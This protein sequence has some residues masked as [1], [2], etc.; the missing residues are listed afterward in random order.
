MTK[1][2]WTKSKRN[3][4][5]GAGTALGMIFLAAAGSAENG[6]APDV[7][8]IQ[9][10]VVDGGGVSCPRDA[11]VTAWAHT[12]GPGTVR[13]V[14]RNSGGGKTGELQ[15]EAVPGAAGTYLATYRHTFKIT[16]DVDTKYM[17]EAV[18][19]G[20]TSNWVP[21][22]ATCGPQPRTS[23]SAKGSTAQPPARAT[24]SRARENV[25][26]PTS[27]SG[28]PPAKPASETKPNSEGKPAGT[29]KPNSSTGKGARQC[30]AK[31]TSTRV[32]AVTRKGGML[33]AQVGWMAAAQKVHPDSWGDW[34]KAKD[35][36][37][38]CNRVGLLFN[39]TASAR[40]CEP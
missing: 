22:K 36:S 30:G 29:S 19:S 7:D 24:E 17:A 35:R 18:G 27:G 6:A 25:G 21:L 26:N 3:L 10:A 20:K 2:V 13:F 11:T 9:L 4:A 28:A 8:R 15:A 40:P 39:C 5:L 23:T 14:I 37:L 33:S 1:H 34:D 32:A 12:N 38:S 31:I 16:A